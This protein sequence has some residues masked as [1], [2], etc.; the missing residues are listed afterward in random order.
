M[1]KGVK[2]FFISIRD[3]VQK[4]AT[5]D[6]LK[7]VGLNDVTAE[8]VLDRPPKRNVRHLGERDLRIQSR[9]DDLSP[10]DRKRAAAMEL[11]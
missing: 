8:N 5:M 10:K 7:V 9:Q 1:S 6:N 2:S 11:P 4:Q 3:E